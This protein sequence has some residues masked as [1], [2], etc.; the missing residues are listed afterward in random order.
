MSDHRH[1]Q[2]NGGQDWAE[3]AHEQLGEAGFRRGGARRAV[4]DVLATGSCGLSAMEIEERLR[5]EGRRAGRASIYRTL[6][7]L[8]ELGVISRLDLAGDTTRYER[9]DPGHHH[10]H[11]ICDSCGKVLP[12]ADPA[13]EDAISAI[14]GGR[15]FTVRDHEIVLHGACEACR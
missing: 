14:S 1:G 5:E 4:I 3:F 6:E 13:L 10:H 8:V 9:V 15:R 7:Q 12:F 11:M 2:S